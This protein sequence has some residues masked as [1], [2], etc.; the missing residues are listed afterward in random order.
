MHGAIAE[1]RAKRA[2]FP[3]IRGS[4]GY[5]R[6][7]RRDRAHRDENISQPHPVV[8]VC[9]DAVLPIKRRLA[10]ADAMPDGGVI[11]SPDHS[12]PDAPRAAVCL[13]AARSARDVCDRRRSPSSASAAE[14]GVGL[15]EPNA[16]QI[17]DIRALGTHWVRVF[18]PGPTSS[19]NAAS[20]RPTG[21]PPT[22]S[23][24]ARCPRAQSHHRRRRLAQLGD[25][26]GDTR[27]R[28]RRTPTTTPP[29]SASWPH[30][31]AGHVAAYEDLERGGRGRA[32]GPAGRT[33]P[34]TRSC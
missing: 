19:R 18:A 21:S 30:Q 20:T 13:R 27:I 10:T 4:L 1:S 29:S 24:S 23:S 32:G 22:N 6:V 33:P 31:W 2:G 12:P 7:G 28:R 14:P 5:R 34:P 16:A 3:C 15:R 11:R 8:P 9:R 17:A 25:R 26:L